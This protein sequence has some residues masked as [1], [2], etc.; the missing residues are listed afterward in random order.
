MGMR[1]HPTQEYQQHTTTKFHPNRFR[2]FVTYLAQILPSQTPVTL[3]QGQD[4]LNQYQNVEVSSNYHHTRLALKW[5]INIQMHTN[6]K[7]V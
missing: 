4:E 6:I 3:T 1:V 7:V 5:F 2:T